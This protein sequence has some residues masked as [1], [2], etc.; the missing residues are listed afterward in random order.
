MAESP[1][2]NENVFVNCPFDDEFIP[3]LHA[4]IYTIYCCGFVP[5]SALAE[6]DGTDLRL[7]KIIRC[8][9]N[10]KYGIHDIS[11]TEL[12]NSNFPRFNMPLSW[13]FSLEQSVLGI[14]SKRIKM[15]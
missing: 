12:N 10:S 3:L 8:I 5:K 1:G 9:N 11:R 7:D 14:R 15:P 2:Y 6:D 13:V 4:I